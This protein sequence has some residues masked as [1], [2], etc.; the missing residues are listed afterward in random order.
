[1]S[2]QNPRELYVTLLSD[3]RRH[4]EHVAHSLREIGE[5]AEDPEIRQTLTALTY[6]SDRTRDTLDQCFAMIGE[7]PV[8]LDDRIQ[9]AFI[10][11]FRNMITEL[12]SPVA[13]TLYI[14]TKAN[15]LMY[16]RVGE[17]KTLIAM[18]RISGNHGVAL[19]LESCLTDKL[20]FVERIRYRVRTMVESEFA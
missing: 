13:K 10:E 20:T 1:M 16:L 19:L 9:E 2:V 14:A 11:N 8:E 7:K 3:L 5:T 17:Y 18:S 15:E 12:E 4:E 6:L